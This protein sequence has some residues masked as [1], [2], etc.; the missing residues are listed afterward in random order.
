VNKLSTIVVVHEKAAPHV[1][2]LLALC[3]LHLA[4]LRGGLK[5]A[6]VDEVVGKSSTLPCEICIQPA[7]KPATAA[8]AAS[9]SDG[10]EDEAAMYRDP[11][12]AE[13][14]AARRELQQGGWA[15]ATLR[16]A[17]FLLRLGQIPHAVFE[18]ELQRFRAR[19]EL[20]TCDYIE[21]LAAAR[22][23]ERIS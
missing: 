21:V 11:S 6:G 23:W 20:P 14:R 13:V 8:V 1:R 7:A 15:G 2:V 18:A 10:T 4:F 3:G 22:L 16:D 9:H 17:R 5:W 19:G 12:L